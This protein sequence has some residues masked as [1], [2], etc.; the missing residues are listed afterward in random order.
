ML[1]QAIRD[2][3]KKRKMKEGG[4]R[5]QRLVLPSGLSQEHG[6]RDCYKALYFFVGELKYKHYWSECIDFFRLHF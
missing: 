6:K 1:L 5:L 3:G 2:V 4:V